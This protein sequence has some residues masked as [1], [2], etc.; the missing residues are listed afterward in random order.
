M[1][2]PPTAVKAGRSAEI[3]LAEIDLSPV[4]T[5]K[6]PKSKLWYEKIMM[7]ATLRESDAI[8]CANQSEGKA[9]RGLTLELTGNAGKR[10][11]ARDMRDH[12]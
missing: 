2:K 11:Q 1:V 10:T 8:A 12:A 6:A 3:D 4:I 5:R 9:L 7:R